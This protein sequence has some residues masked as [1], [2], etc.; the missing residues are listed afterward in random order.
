M[1]GKISSENSE[2]RGIFR[3]LTARARIHYKPFYLHYT[4]IEAL[5]A[6]VIGQLLR[7]YFCKI[8]KIPVDALFT[9]TND[10]ENDRAVRHIIE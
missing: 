2:S 8:D 10:C 7:G 6:D 9:E 5:F 3:E 1:S 4:C